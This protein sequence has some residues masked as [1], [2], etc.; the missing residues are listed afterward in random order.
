MEAQCVCIIFA[1]DTDLCDARSFTII[2]WSKIC[3]L[4]ESGWVGAWMLTIRV[5]FFREDNQ[6]GGVGTSVPTLN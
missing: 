2:G 5:S 1:G 6:D 3:K 4:Q